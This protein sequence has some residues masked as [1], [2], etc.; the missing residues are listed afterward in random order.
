MNPTWCDSIFFALCEGKYSFTV[1]FSHAIPIATMIFCVWKCPIQQ[2]EN[3]MFFS[4]LHTLHRVLHPPNQMSVRIHPLGWQGTTVLGG[5]PSSRS[6]FILCLWDTT[7]GN[8]LRAPNEKQNNRLGK[9][10]S[11]SRS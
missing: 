10:A 7:K 2:K 4:G 1:R 11:F 8:N 5:S 6:L 9:M 3:E